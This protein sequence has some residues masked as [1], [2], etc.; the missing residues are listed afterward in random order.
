[1]PLW[2]QVPPW[3]SLDFCEQGGHGHMVVE[4]GWVEKPH[5]V[6]RLPCF[7]DLKLSRPI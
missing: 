2:S 4:E 3:K 5:K 7:A 1:M 6:P